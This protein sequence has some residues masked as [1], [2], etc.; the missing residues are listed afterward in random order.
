MMGAGPALLLVHGT[1]ASTHSWR[2]VMPILARHYSVIAADLPGHGFTEPL[3]GN[4]GSIRGMSDALAA[5]LQALDISPQYCVGHSAGAVV[6]CKMALDQLMAPRVIVSINGAFIPLRGAAGIL[7]SPIARLL[8]NVDFIPRLLAKRTRAA[9]VARLIAGT[10]STLDA[11][12]VDLYTRLVRD[13]KHLAGA[14]GM[15]GHWDLYAFQQELPRLRTPLVL[16]VGENDLTIPPLQSLS[17]QKRV[18]NAVVRRLAGLGHLAHE[19]E[20]ALIAQELLA[21]FATK[22]QG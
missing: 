6:L 7:F 17:I 4:R 15:M 8:A 5:L 22:G 3:R 9:D 16:L 20:P 14:L 2:D 1:G 19:E 10:G 13:P 21:I 12:G 18:D 11:A